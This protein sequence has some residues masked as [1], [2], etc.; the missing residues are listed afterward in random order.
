ML[1]LANHITE[2]QVNCRIEKAEKCTR[3]SALI[4]AMNVKSHS[5][6]I[7]AGQFIAESVGQREDH[8]EEIE[9]IRPRISER[10]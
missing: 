5:N 9:G 10:S 4:V 3:Q 7:Q 1:V 6:L 2:V 8:R